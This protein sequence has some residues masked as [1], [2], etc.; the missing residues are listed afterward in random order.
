MKIL[1]LVPFLPNTETS[2]GQ[3]RWYN[4]IK[5][6]S[7]EHEITLF[8][9]I[10]DDS[11]RKFIEP[12]QNYC[13]KVEVFRRPKSPWTLRNLFLTAFSW[14]PL[15]VIRNLS[16]KEKKAIKEELASEKYDLIHAETFYVMP[17]IPESPVPSIMVEQT[18]E[19]QVYKHY[20]DH[21]VP[22]LLRPFFMIDVIKLKYWEQF[23]WKKA[24]RAVAV[25]EDDKK[26]MQKLVPDMLVDVIP[27]GVDSAFYAEKKLKRDNPP[28][29]LYGVS[30]FEWLQNQ[31]AARVLI[32]EVWP[33]IKKQNIK[34]RLWIVGRIMPDWLKNIAGK[35]EDI[36]IT[37]NIPDARDAYRTASVMVAPIKSGGGTRL[38]VLEAMAAG[39]PI[40]STSVG[41]ASLGL[42]NGKNVVIADGPINMAKKT[43]ELLKNPKKAEKIG[44]AGKEF[45]EKNYDWKAIVKLHDPIYEEITKKS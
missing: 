14:Y 8:S 36:E 6:M 20:V 3:T 38:K 28:K 18:I 39:L 41:V 45:V 33:K 23:F 15:L 25:S 13:K 2:G 10:K 9:L 40:V 34:T 35:R 32:D 43:A 1:M 7:T 31:E 22:M 37:E 16:P 27:N 24:T 29:V 44:R 17:H 26:I 21:E 12:L 19:Y 11:E 30:N 42:T 4:L 5:Y